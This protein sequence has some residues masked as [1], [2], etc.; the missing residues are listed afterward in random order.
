[1]KLIVFIQPDKFI[2]LLTNDKFINEFYTNDYYSENIIYINDV[3]SFEFG[4]YEKSQVQNAPILILKDSYNNENLFDGLNN[5]FYVLRHGNN[6]Q[7]MEFINSHSKFKGC[8][9]QQ[10]EPTFEGKETLYSILAKKIG[11]SDSETATDFINNNFVKE[12]DYKNNLDIALNFLHKC[13][14]S[15]PPLPPEINIGSLYGEW[16]KTPNEEN[17][18]KLRDVVL[19]WAEN[20]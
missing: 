13:L 3:F 4:D 17:L 11:N 9:Q 5:D 1:M 7:L 18:S 16:V 14:V 20:K 19:Q 6:P 15:T 12:V 8:I 10:E 2:S